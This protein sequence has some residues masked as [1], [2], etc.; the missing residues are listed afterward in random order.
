[1]VHVSEEEMPEEFAL[2]CPDLQSLIEQLH[3]LVVVLLDPEGHFTTWHPGVMELFGYSADEFIGQSAE[4]LLPVS[5]R[6]RGVLAGI[7]AQA[8][9]SGRA[10]YTRWLEKKTG[11]GI[12]VDG[13]TV[14]LR[15][16]AGA[17]TGFG[18]V[19]H[20]VTRRLEMQEALETANQRLE[21]MAVE[22]ERS[23][24][25]L[26]EFARITSHDLSAPVTS[27][28]W[29][30]DLLA[31]RYGQQL[32]ER[33][34]DCVAQISVSLERM[35]ALIDAVLE[36]AMVGRSAIA[37]AGAV[38]AERALEVALQNL[39]KDIDISNATVHYDPLPALGIDGQALSRLF[40]NLVSNAIKYRRPET[41]PTVK[42]SAARDGSMWLLSVRDNGI[43]IPP[44][45]YERIF[46]P[47]Q[48]LHGAGVPGTG[49]GLATCKKIVT[50]AGGKIWVESQDGRRLHVHVH[51]ARAGSQR[52]FDSRLGVLM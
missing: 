43:G 19:L 27:A 44:E 22:L 9:N 50:R 14:A 2:D 17:I 38:P 42:I 30:A 5:D 3:E 39:Q 33:G 40:Q 32:D 49:I 1:M 26:E 20:E 23:N 8:E 31:S 4:L 35:A 29:L 10:G 25:E 48:R 13:V 6:G 37:S 18:K 12:F 46:V 11:Q 51:A 36:H 47:M 41:P 7:L 34:R 24:E 16:E 52:G 21:R 28:R 15:N 45:S